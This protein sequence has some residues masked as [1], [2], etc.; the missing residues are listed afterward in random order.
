MQINVNKPFRHLLF[1]LIPLILLT[2]FI[3]VTLFTYSARGQTIPRPDDPQ[4]LRYLPSIINTRASIPPATNQEYVVIG[5]NDLGMHCYD[6][7]YSLMAVL[8]PYNT[9]WAQ[10]IQRGNPPKIVTD[11]VAVEYSFAENT[12][13]DNKTNFWVYAEKLFNTPLPL[14]IGLKGFGLSGEMTSDSDHF[15]AEGIPLTEYSDS[16]LTTPDYLQMSTIV[17]RDA[18]TNEILATSQVVAP[19]SSEMRCDTCHT[20]PY[21]G[22]FRRNIL[23]KHDEEEE[24][25]NLLAQAN[26]GNPVLCA[27]CHADPALGAPGNP[28]YPSLS[29]AMHSAHAEEFPSDPYQQNCYACHPGPNTKCLRDVMSTQF[30]LT[31]VDCHVGGMRAL[32]QGNRTPWLDEPRCGNCHDTAHTEE[33]GTLYRFSKGHGGLYCESCHNSTHAILTSR[34]APDNQQSILLQGYAGTIQECS[35]CHT[36]QPTAGGPHQ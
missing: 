25:T 5:W 21:P 30:D 28:S 15:I 3:G 24:G 32:A 1:I 16:S 4:Y 20:E 17:A 19:V 35:V 27:D 36:V 13:S 31:C 22:D 26:S 2:I 10:V 29:R 18:L 6:R 23:A 11:G 34:D 8:P 33:E 12:R 9:L 7:E 14:N